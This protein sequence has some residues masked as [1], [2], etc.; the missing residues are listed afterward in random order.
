MA[1]SRN[2]RPR[3]GTGAWERVKRLTRYQFLRI[4]RLRASPHTIALGLALGIFVGFLPIVPFQSVVVI[5]LAFVLRGSKVA[6]FLGTWISN[7]IDLP[8]FY[9]G[10]FLVGRTL[11]PFEGV[12]FDPEHL[13]MAEM[14][15]AGWRLFAIMCVGGVIL[16]VPSSLITYLVTRRVVVAYRRRKSRRLLVRRAR[17]T[18]VGARPGSPPLLSWAE[19]RQDTEVW[20]ALRLSPSR[21]LMLDFDGTLSPFVDDPDTAEFHPGVR[22]LLRDIM[23]RPGC[24]VVFVTGRG[25][26]DL[27]RRM[28]LETSPE[29]WGSHGGERL[30]PSGAKQPLDMSSEQRQGLERA[31]AWAAQRGLASRLEHKPGCLAFHLR[32]LPEAEAAPLHSRVLTSWENLAV[33]SGLDMHEFDGGVELRIPGYHKGRA[34]RCILDE[35]G[36]GAVVFYLGD[37]VTDEDAFAALGVRGVSVLVRAEPRPTLAAWH[38]VPPGELLEFLAAWRD[39]C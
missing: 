22:D 14:L 9:Y 3:Q 33:E 8:F 2:N 10:L 28:G 30:L 20:K 18:R 16:G 4:M 38:L 31:E 26:E 19:A 1:D 13:A 24:R 5:A 29:V 39:A 11:L 25:A 35:E 17:F 36:D 37:D 6:G 23:A 15:D 32:G 7:P 12:S 27:A 34:V 21:V